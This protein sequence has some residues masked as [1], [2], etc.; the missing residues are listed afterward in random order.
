MD[1]VI[2]TLILPGIGNSGPEHWQSQWERRDHSCQRVLQEEWDAPK[3]AAWAR[4]DEVI[5]A[6]RSPVVLAAHSSACALVAHWAAMASPDHIARVHGALLVGPSDPDG[7][8]YP[9]GPIGFSPVPLQR[10][11]FPRS[12]L[13]VPMTPSSRSRGLGSTPMRGTA[14]LSCWKTRGTSML[15]AG[16]AHGPKDM[17]C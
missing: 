2:A 6:Q 11:L 16:M 10:F 17:P 12:S 3:C 8:N 13:Q 5:A 14:G 9:V 15:P 1:E 7:P 4:L